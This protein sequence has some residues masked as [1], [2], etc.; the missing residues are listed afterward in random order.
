MSRFCVSKAHTIVSSVLLPFSLHLPLS[1]ST[2]TQ[3]CESNV[4]SH[5]ATAPAPGLPERCHASCRGSHDTESKPQCALC[6]ISCLGAG[7]SS[8]QWKGN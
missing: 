3:T 5:S 2:S 4:G 6:S 7:A 1:P 8:Q